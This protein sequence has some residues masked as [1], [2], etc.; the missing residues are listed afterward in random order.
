L[1]LNIA[2][3]SEI[4][5]IDWLHRS[6]RNRENAARSARGVGLRSA[7]Q[8]YEV[9]IDSRLRPRP[10][11]PPMVSLSIRRSVKSCCSAV[12][13]KSLC[14]YAFLR[15]LY[16][17]PLS[18]CANVTSSVKLEM[19]KCIAVQPQDDRA[20]AISNM[21]TKFGEYWTCGSGDILAGRQTHRLT[22]ITILRSSTDGE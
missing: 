19:H 7:S 10:V 4:R 17:W 14:V 15:R 5:R 11:L 20:T 9:I 2:P 8:K 1:A 16:L 18:S 21:L 3:Q 22:L 6:Y 12:P 13:A